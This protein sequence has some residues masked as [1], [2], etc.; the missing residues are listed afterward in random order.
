[1]L[2]TT[3]LGGNDNLFSST[4]PYLTEAGVSFSTTLISKIKL[5]LDVDEGHAVVVNYGYGA[6][7]CLGK[8]GTLT[9]TR[10]TTTAMPEL[11]SLALLR[12]GL[13]GV[14]MVVRR[15]RGGLALAA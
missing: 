10:V 12:S 7:Y 14:G 13:A 11:G 5:H 6:D 8:G 4:E 9:V 15:R 1:L 2:A 3:S